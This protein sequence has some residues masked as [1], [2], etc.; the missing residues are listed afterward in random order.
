MKGIKGGRVSVVK[1]IEQTTLQLSTQMNV[2]HFFITLVLIDLLFTFDNFIPASKPVAISTLVPAATSVIYIKTVPI[3]EGFMNL[4]WKLASLLIH[5]PSST[6]FAVTLLMAAT[7]VLALLLHCVV[8]PVSKVVHD[9]FDAKPEIK[10]SEFMTNEPQSTKSKEDPSDDR[11]DFELTD[12]GQH[13]QGNLPRY[14]Q[15]PACVNGFLEGVG[16]SQLTPEIHAVPSDTDVKPRK[17]SYAEAVGFEHMETRKPRNPNF[18]GYADVY[19]ADFF[20]EP[21]PPLVKVA[22]SEP[23]KTT[24]HYVADPKMIRLVEFLKVSGLDQL[25]ILTKKS[26]LKINKSILFNPHYNTFRIVK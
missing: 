21:V 19:L 22:I 24:N 11:A 23:I 4:T 14:P 1:V 13:P 25:H 9:N 8:F 2:F 5:A 17:L 7:A 12:F 15:R 3:P 26:A 18:M 10:T 6:R 16:P 20:K